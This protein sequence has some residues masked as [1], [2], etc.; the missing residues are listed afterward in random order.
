VHFHMQIAVY[1]LEVDP[2]R[3]KLK[4]KSSFNAL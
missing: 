1:L 4:G 2:Y 3:M